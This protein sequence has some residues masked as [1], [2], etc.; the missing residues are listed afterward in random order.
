[1]PIYVCHCGDVQEVALSESGAFVLDDTQ[2]CKW[3]CYEG[4]E[5]DMNILHAMIP[6]AQA[7]GC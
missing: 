3:Y 2:G 5:E 1:M 6:M 4:T 7:Q